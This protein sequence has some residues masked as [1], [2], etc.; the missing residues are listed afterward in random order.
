M[1]S[2]P[3]YNT[4]RGPI[5]PRMMNTGIVIALLAVGAVIG[6]GTYRHFERRH[7]HSV[8]LL[9]PAPIAKIADPSPVAV[10]GQVAEVFGNKFVIQDDS[11]R[12]LVDTGPR[13]ER[14]P[15]VAKGDTVTVQGNFER[16]FLHAEV[17]IRADGTTEGF[18]PPRHPRHERGPGR[19][20]PPR[21]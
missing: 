21:T 9:Q 12:V 19:D 18:G 2:E 17:M 20:F 16:G 15:P 5:P 14:T 1:P 10:K 4:P 3:T 7:P 6:A 8:L 13:G 11:G